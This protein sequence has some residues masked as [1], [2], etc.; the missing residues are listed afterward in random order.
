V[1]GLRGAV[2]A[3]AQRGE[4]ELLEFLDKEQIE[5]E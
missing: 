5:H 3:A 1:K 4:L 2:L